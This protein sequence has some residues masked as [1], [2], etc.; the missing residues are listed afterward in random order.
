MLQSTGSQRVGHDLA[1]ERQSA[2]L[3]LA[4]CGEVGT[5]SLLSLTDTDLLPGASES[6]CCGHPA[7]SLSSSPGLP[8]A[9]LHWRVRPEDPSLANTVA[10]HSVSKHLWV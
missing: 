9:S 3:Q 1:T 6:C 8:T 4:L 10:V 5:L 2:D 7:S